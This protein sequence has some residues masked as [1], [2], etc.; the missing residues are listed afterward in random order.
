MVFTACVLQKNKIHI[1][2][3]KKKYQPINNIQ[4]YNS[5]FVKD[6]NS[7]NS[8]TY[9]YKMEEESDYDYD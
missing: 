9:S 7:S 2:E 3:L 4:I 5:D 6:N 8:N 1:E